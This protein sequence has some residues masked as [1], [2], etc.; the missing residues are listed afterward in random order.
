MAPGRPQGARGA[1]NG[2]IDGTR[3]AMN[4]IRRGLDRL[5]WRLSIAI[6]AGIIV[7]IAV[8]I[9]LMSVSEN[10]LGLLED[11]ENEFAAY[12]VVFAM[13]YGDAVIA[14]L[15]GETSLNVASVV[16][17]DDKL[18][19]WLVII[20][21]GLGAALGDNTLYWIARS[22]PGIRRR[23]EKLKENDSVKKATDI[24]GDR[25]PVIIFFCRYIPGVRFAV[26][27]SMGAIR[28]PYR[29]Y[30]PWSVIGAF[31]LATYTCLMAF[32]IGTALDEFPVA[33]IVVAGASSGVFV[34]IG[35]F[36]IRRTA[37]RADSETPQAS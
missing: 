14:V 10:A 18:D 31:V 35:Y 19:L 8:G 27:A 23:V 26:T 28:Y 5:T 3:K 25:G 22:I 21:G 1:E 13:V 16:A 37:K 12:F 17:A 33:S 9:I 4:Y 20:A 7:L 6:V 34:A 30:L 15:P 29:S 24:M 11:P 32:V 2:G 36:V